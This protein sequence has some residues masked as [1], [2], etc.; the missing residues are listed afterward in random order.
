[1]S[2]PQFNYN[3]T[4]AQNEV[5]SHTRTSEVKTPKNPNL[6]AMLQQKAEMQI[7]MLMDKK[8][9]KTNHTS[10]SSYTRVSETKRTVKVD[11]E[12]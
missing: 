7:K 3:N 6:K 2:A 10:T 1:M 9:A 11:I 8:L 5:V 4:L 12:K